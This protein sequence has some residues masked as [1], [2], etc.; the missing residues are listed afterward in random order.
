MTKVAYR[1]LAS[2]FQ[3]G[4]GMEPAD[5]LYPYAFAYALGC[6]AGQPRP[7]TPRS[8]PRPA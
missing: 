1:V 3:D 5:L 4:T 6:G 7:S 2:P 8:P